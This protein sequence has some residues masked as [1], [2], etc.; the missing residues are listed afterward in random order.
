METILLASWTT[1]KWSTT[2]MASGRPVRIAAR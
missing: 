1:W 2:T